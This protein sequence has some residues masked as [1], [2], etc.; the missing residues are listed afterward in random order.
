[1]GDFMLE[2]DHIRYTVDGTEI[3]K[4]ISTH[5][6]PGRLS[7]IIGPNGS[8]K[9]T[10]MKIAGLEFSPTSGT[11]SYGG[12]TMG[13]RDREELARTRAALSQNLSL[14]F[15]LTVAEVVM[16]GRYPHFSFK[17]SSRD[18]DICVLAMERAGV[19]GLRDRNY[20]TLSGGEK[21]MTQFARVLAQIWEAPPGEPRYLLLDE[22]T[23]FLD[24]NH[25]HHLLQALRAIAAGN[26][27]VAAV[28]HDINLAS[29][30]G[31]FIVALHRGVRV[32][33]GTPDEVITPQI[34][35]ALYGM[36]GRMI[37]ND[38]LEFPLIV[39]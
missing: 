8:G 24:V 35:Q 16:M 31:D 26:V 20:L 37:K 23:T 32:A 38:D 11:V 7:L 12:R 36:R 39:F 25:Q 4:G 13:G 17:P 14:P 6:E 2:L 18:H 9:S 29:Q 22:P 19:A 34:F 21:Q 30:Y 15:P 28:I 27:V 3:L 1:M 10:L 33:E 5:F